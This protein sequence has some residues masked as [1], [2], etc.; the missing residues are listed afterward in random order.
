[1]KTPFPKKEYHSPKYFL[2]DANGK[3][4][5][6]LSAEV[7]K[8]LRGKDSSFFAPGVDQGNFVAIINAEKIKISGK[9]QD[10]K[11]YYRP[12]QR[13]GNLKEENFKK[14]NSRIPSKI[15]EESIWGMLPKGKLGRQYYKRL[16]ICSS[17]LFELE[18]DFFTSTKWE[19]INLI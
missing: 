10:Q 3:T 6:R 15:L 19:K 5:G 14:L 2:I 8:L 13:P 18:K 11:L 9:K 7:S 4:L 17:K 12:T 1:M 16:F